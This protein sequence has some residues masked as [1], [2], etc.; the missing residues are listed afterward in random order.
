MIDGF[1]VPDDSG[2]GFVNFA[3]SKA[4]NAAYIGPVAS[5]H[6][7]AAFY[8]AA[9]SQ[10]ESGGKR[11]CVILANAALHGEHLSSLLLLRK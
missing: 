3:S 4:L 2:Y 11:G 1:E 6:D 8:P 10:S 9:P 5:A 7:L